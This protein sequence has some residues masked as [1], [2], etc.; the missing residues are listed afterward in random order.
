MKDFSKR[1]A[2]LSPEQRALLEAR[3]KKKGLEPLKIQEQDITRRRSSEYLPLSFVQEQLWF[4]D[5]LA[6][7]NANY[8]H[9]PAVRLNGPLKVEA[10][11][12]SLNEIVRRHEALRTTFAAV[13]GQPIQVIT[14]SL[15]VPLRLVDL[16]GVPAPQREAEAQRVA[17]EEIHHPFD[18]ARGPLIR[19]SLLRLEE[20]EHVVLLL[21]HHIIS[22]GWSDGIL[23]RDLA[24]LYEAFS[25]GSPSPLPDLPIQYADYALWQREWL[26]GE[27]LESLLA[28]WKQQLG[29]ELPVLKLPTDRPRPAIQSIRG[30]RHS[31]ALPKPLTQAIKALSRREGVTLFMTLLAAFKAL[32]FRYTGQDDLLVGSTLA[33][34]TRREVEDLIGYFVNTIVLRINLAGNPSFRGLLRRVSKITL[35]AQAHQALPFE[36]LVKE[37]APR[38]DLSR[39]PLFQVLFALQNTPMPTIAL[40]GIS[41]SPVDFSPGTVVFDLTLSMEDTEQG[42]VGTFEYA[43]DLFDADTIVR[44]AEHFKTML[45]GIVSNPEQHISDLPLLTPSEWQ[46]AVVEWNANQAEYPR[47]TCLHQLFEAQ[48]ERTPEA[49]AIVFEGESLIYRELNRRANRLA[50]YLQKLGVGP[51]VPVGM[52]MERSME[53]VIGLLGILKAG[54][55]YIPLDPTYPKARLALMVE[56]TRTPLLLTQKR[57]M[58]RL[59]D[60]RAQVICLDTVWEE[61]AYE[62]ED[63]P[64]NKAKAEKLVYITYSSDRAI[65]VEHRGVCNR[66]Q[67]LQDKFSLSS[68]DAVLQ[69]APLTLDTSVWEILWPLVYGGRLVIAEASNPKY[70][71]RLIA[72]QQVNIVHFTPLALSAFLKSCGPEVIQLHSLRAI[73]CSGEPLSSTVV[74]EFLQWFGCEYYLSDRLSEAR[75][76]SVAGRNKIILV[77]LY[78]PPEAALACSWRIRQLDD[79]HGSVPVGYPANNTSIYVLDEHMQPVP[80]GVA[81]EIYIAGDGLA[82]GYLHDAKDAVQCFVK[83]PFSDGSLFKSGDPGR[84][85]NNGA[86]K[87][88]ETSRRHTWIGGFRV[89]LSTVEAALLEDPSVDECV[90][91]A[92]K[93]QT[94]DQEL[95]AYIVR[96]GL[97]TSDSLE[98][99]LQATLPDYMLPRAYVPLATLPLTSTGEVDR[100]ALLNLEVIDSDLVQRWQERLR[101]APEIEHVAV[102]IQQQAEHL[103]SYHL[104]DLLLSKSINSMPDTSASAEM[105]RKS[106][107]TYE[108]SQSTRLAISFGGSLQKA[109]DAPATLPETLRRAAL[110]SPEKGILYLQA[111]GTETFQSYPAL[112]EEAQRV[113]AGLRKLGLKPQDKV[114]FQFDRNEDFFAALWGCLLGGFVP[115]PIAIAP[116]YEQ[117]N[118]TVDKL[119]NAWK[120]LG[121]PIVLTRCGR[122]AEVGSLSKLLNLEHFQVEAIDDLRTQEADQSWHTSQP[123][124]LA[125]L[126]LT[127]GSTG[128]PKGVM[129]NHRNILGKVAGSTQMY[130]F[131]DQDISLNWMPLEHPGGV[132]RSHIRDVYLGSQQIHAPTRAVLEDPLKWLNWIDRYRATITWAPNFAFRLVY[133]HA[134]EISQ[135]HWDLSS[136]RFMINAGEAIVARTARRFLELLRPYGLPATA[137]HPVWGM[138]E[139][140]SGVVY[141]DRFSPD[142]TT[143]EDLFVEVGPP[144]PGISLRIVDAQNQVVSEDTIGRLQVKGLTVTSGYYQNPTLNQEVFTDDGWFITGDLGILHEGRLTITGREKDVI[145]ING[146]NY[147]G[148]EIEAVVEE[149]T[150]VEAS[151]TAACAVRDSDSNT[152]QLAIFFRSALSD[153]TRLLEQMKE[154]RGKV[155]SEVGVSL[156]YVIPVERAAI[157]KTEIG[158]IQR[159]ALSQRLAAGEFNPILKHLDVLSSNANTLPDWFYQKVWRQ[160]KIVTLTTRPRI[161]RLLVFLDQEGLG[162]LVCEE[163]RRLNLAYVSVETGE[164]FTRISSDHYQINPG[165]PGHYQRL[166]EAIAEDRLDIDQ[167]LHLWT[168]GKYAGEVA[169]PEE[170][171][172]SQ[173]PGV[174]SLLW[175]AQAL[176]KFERATRLY[177]ISSHT[178]PVWPDDQ[179]AYEKATVLGFLKTLPQ[180]MPWLSYRHVD[181]PA[182]QV[183]LDA[184]HILQELRTVQK[185]REVAYRS[186]QRLI[187]RLKK[188]DLRQE[189]K[190][191]LPF[192][193]GR[194]YLLSGGLGGIGVELA[195]YLLKQ[196][197]V[198]LLLVGRTALPERDTWNTYLEQTNTV[199]Q[200]IKNYLALEQLGGEVIYKAVDICDVAQ[201]QQVVEQ[202]KLQWQCELDGIIHL[203]GTLQEHLLVDETRGSFAA[204]LR[205]KVVGTWALHQLLKDRPQ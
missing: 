166:L 72:E 76:Q 66:L 68:S 78:G 118:N 71:W 162:T 48:V 194:M 200:R 69:Q 2:D 43:T 149:V 58:E 50:H 153:E 4:L 142:S 174:Y 49:T 42:L 122:V 197:K 87:L 168:Y 22:D 182:D 104:S 80:V 86:L 126:L 205:P 187:P 79:A 193:P 196:H 90:V 134:Q 154:I 91:L 11:E 175:L 190:R 201:L 53:M 65:L 160:K 117:S 39:N 183:E 186:N 82:R 151:Y 96:V 141:S 38:R 115:V 89:E 199:A 25:E 152:D 61:F 107:A 41:L 37:I 33:N 88:L 123:E 27:V 170:L 163:L 34:R 64:V 136:M 28:Y 81:G 101:S 85:L 8:N 147:Y 119:H 181:L 99:H 138:A 100:Q 94:G 111:D 171:E 1:I 30:A 203:A 124:D 202:A 21:I 63:N 92:R 113:L 7:G 184:K 185:A 129:L 60:L 16:Q 158:K 77:N 188:V 31:F 23:L 164:D 165:E 56:D 146:V 24:T 167:I 157:P 140:S 120:M 14:P 18:L 112:L 73:L 9:Y 159:S 191:E 204:T 97:F 156:A 20:Q 145:I 15:T 177:V 110:Q 128:L 70:L 132:V 192:K 44:M 59:P 83:H 180:E 54:G 178:Q 67:W 46:Q 47:D 139:T 137:M 127:S 45:E 105:P 116:T 161:G 52:C 131:S 93:T 176:A 62:R 102:L 135:G 121:Q 75:T 19:A 125:L 13:E 10:L 6:P 108:A 84:R 144:L 32:L 179:L 3:L 173:V 189:K 5:Q 169:S 55:A 36:I 106:A 57:L 143:D 195:R 148:H 74:D 98:A 172:Q 51:E 35:G 198:R 26:Q 109:L 12:Q 150:D 40:S 103:P 133:D 29:G 114:I 17:I 130:S 155:T 95:V